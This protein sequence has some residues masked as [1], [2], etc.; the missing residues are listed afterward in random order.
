MEQLDNLPDNSSPGDLQAAESTLKSI[1]QDLRHLR[2]SL[3]HDIKQLQT[4]RSNLAHD[5]EVLK[6]E[7][8]MLQA[9]Q[10]A[11]LSRQQVAQQELWA[12]RLAQSLASHLQERLNRQMQQSGSNL[13]TDRNLTRANLASSSAI[14][15]HSPSE[16]AHQLLTSLDSTLNTTLQSLKQDLN[17]YQSDLS[18]QVNRMHSLERQGEAILDALVERLSQHLQAQ[19]TKTQAN[20]LPPL[21]DDSNRSEYNQTAQISRQGLYIQST[22]SNAVST[23]S[24]DIATSK[25]DDALQPPTTAARGLAKSKQGLILILLSTIALSVHNVVV[26]LIGY[27]GN[28]FRQLPLPQLIEYSIPNALLVLALR[29][30]VVVPLMALLAARLY[31]PVWNDI[32]RFTKAGAMKPMLGVIGSGFFLFLSQVLVYTAIG[33]IGAGLAVTILFMY[34]LVTVPLAWFLFGD[35]PTKLRIGVMAA[36]SAG[37]IFAALPKL[38]LSG[39]A[40][41]WGVGTAVLSGISFA[42]YLVSMQI[43]FRKLHPIPVSLIQ[44]ATIFVLALFM[45]TLIGGADIEPLNWPGLLIGCV[46]LGVLTLIG[47]FLNNLGVRLMGAA[48]ASIVASSGPVLTAVLAFLITPGEITA[49]KSV[50]IFGIFL[51]TLGVAALSCEGSIN[52]KRNQTSN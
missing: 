45:L 24:R 20:H 50:Q 17:T 23:I 48:R 5:I 30:F 40:S 47:Y 27:G 18:Q 29:M 15:P 34:P 2:Q 38:S 36:I 52:S 14:A 16:N 11:S 22:V 44:F 3:L 42:C 32:K 4:E 33:Q 1:T 8:Q 9:N 31:P 19:V 49:F 7:H 10:Q 51:V 13:A 25:V 37:I 46:V 35:R 41:V 39:D 6:S 12:K 28:L 26:G 21:A 43:S